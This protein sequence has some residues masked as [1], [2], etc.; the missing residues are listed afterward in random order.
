M[1]NMMLN[2]E[3]YVKIMMWWL[4]VTVYDDMLLYFQVVM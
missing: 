4:T 3:S 1:F 2:L